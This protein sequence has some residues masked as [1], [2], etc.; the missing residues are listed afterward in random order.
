MD[1]SRLPHPMTY[2]FADEVPASTLCMEDLA[3]AYAH[4]HDIADKTAISD[5]AG[6]CRY[7][8]AGWIPWPG[9]RLNGHARCVVTADFQDELWRLWLRSKELSLAVA[10]QL[11]G[12]PQGYIKSWLA[13]AERRHRQSRI[14]QRRRRPADPTA[15]L[16]RAK[17]I[18]SGRSP[19]ELRRLNIAAGL[20]R[21]GRPRD[22]AHKQCS[23]CRRLDRERRPSVRKERTYS[24]SYQAVYCR[25]KRSANQERGRCIND[26]KTQSHGPPLSGRVRCQTCIDRSSNVKEPG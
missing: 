11:C 7:C 13:H 18:K 4:S 26:T 6:K 23:E 12:V 19:A 22:G 20:C 15:R 5:V 1:K 2:E 24:T 25:K 17:R 10:S 21:C 14:K 16:R 3:T 8:G 9:T